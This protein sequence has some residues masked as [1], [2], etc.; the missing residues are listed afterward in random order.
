[1]GG[2]SVCQTNPGGREKKKAL[3]YSCPQID[4]SV[5]MLIKSLPRIWLC[6]NP[7][8]AMV[9]LLLGKF[10]GKTVGLFDGKL[11]GL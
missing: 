9:G 1:M 11:V 3:S 4:F 10:E 5:S 8:A 2:N 7:H 6:D